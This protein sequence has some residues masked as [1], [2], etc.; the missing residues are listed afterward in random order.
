MP[1]AG[2][3]REA[4]GLEYSNFVSIVNALEF[5]NRLLADGL[6]GKLTHPLTGLKVAAYYGCLLSRGEDIVT[7]E[8]A[9]NPSGMEA[10]IRAAGV[11]AEK[12]GLDRHFVDATAVACRNR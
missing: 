5:A 7:G 11:E 12:I 2:R 6:A 8:D 10:A 3:M 4:A 1:L 9:E